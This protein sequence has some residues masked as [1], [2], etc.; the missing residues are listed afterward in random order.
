MRWL[1][2]VRRDCRSIAAAF[3]ANR[4]GRL[5]FWRHARELAHARRIMIHSLSSP[6]RGSQLVLRTRVRLN[7]DVQTDI[8]ASWANAVPQAEAQDLIA[9]HFRGVAAATLGWPAVTAMARLGSKLL[10]V[11]GIA[12]WALSLR[13]AWL[14]GGRALLDALLSDGAFWFGV[15]TLGIGTLLRTALRLWFRRRFRHGLV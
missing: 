2:S 8:L 13:H 3:A 1:G 5:G 10:L 11:A 9:A 15:I 12:A 6:A 4:D 14:A 7:G